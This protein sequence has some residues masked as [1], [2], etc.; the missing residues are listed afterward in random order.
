MFFQEGE[1]E[2]LKSASS[3]L[4]N[5]IGNMFSKKDVDEMVENAK[6]DFAREKESFEKL[7]YEAKL[8]DEINIKTKEDLE[9]KCANLK[10]S[11]E[12]AQTAAQKKDVEV[13]ENLKKLES[14]NKALLNEI[15]E[16]TK[17]EKQLDDTIKTLS[18]Q[19]ENEKSNKDK[20]H[21]EVERIKK[22]NQN[23][24]NVLEAQMKVVLSEKGILEDKSKQL[25]AELSA[26]KAVKTV[27]GSGD[28]QMAAWLEEKELVASEINFLNSIIVDMQNKNEALNQRIQFLELG[29]EASAL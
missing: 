26:L 17:Y 2:K 23:Q 27:E 21:I 16:K 1:L 25:S 6:R 9:N 24:I 5:E 13:T 11:L 14:S 12:L 7:I 8:K 22:E 10:T 20:F 28:N 29:E 3:A 19:L 18:K 15:N 4:S